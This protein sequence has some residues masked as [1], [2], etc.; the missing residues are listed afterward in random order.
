MF[1]T[2]DYPPLRR[3]FAD[4]VST[5]KGKAESSVRNKA[6]INGS[7]EELKEHLQR[8]EKSCGVVASSLDAAV[9]AKASADR[10][11]NRLEEKVISPLPLHLEQAC[12]L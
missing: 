11:A 3:L 10:T 9:T 1:L 2:A 4:E 12:V 8:R 5:W 6:A 7:Y